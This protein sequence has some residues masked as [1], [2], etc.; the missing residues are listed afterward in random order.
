[1]NKEFVKVFKKEDDD[2]P[3]LRHKPELA[4]EQ[5]LVDI[6]ITEEKTLKKLKELNK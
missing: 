2:L 1:M 6:Q 3:I 4:E 5:K